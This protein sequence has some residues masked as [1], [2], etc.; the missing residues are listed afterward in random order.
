MEGA[1][2][3]SFKSLEPMIPTRELRELLLLL[4]SVPLH[5]PPSSWLLFSKSAHFVVLYDSQHLRKQPKN[6]FRWH[7]WSNQFSQGSRITYFWMIWCGLKSSFRFFNCFA[8]VIGHYPSVQTKTSLVRCSIAKVRHT[9]S[10]LMPNLH[11]TLLPNKKVP[12]SSTAWWT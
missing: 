11:Q 12:G 9:V 3:H 6:I 2:V 8:S 10:L 7:I 1:A 4:L 5:P